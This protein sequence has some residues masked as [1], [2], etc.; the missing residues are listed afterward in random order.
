M[1]KEVLAKSEFGE[2]IIVEQI[3]EKSIL[4]HSGNSAEHLWKPLHKIVITDKVLSLN[5]DLSFIHPRTG[6]KFI[7][8]MNF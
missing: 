2:N 6:K 8:S 7:I 3:Y 1:L 4:M 5:E